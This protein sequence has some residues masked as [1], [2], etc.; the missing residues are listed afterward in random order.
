MACRHFFKVVLEDTIRSGKLEIPRKFARDYGN[1]LSNPVFIKVPNGEI[2]ELEF[3]KSGGKMWLQDGWQNFAEHYSVEPGHFL[4]FKYEG[5]GYFHVIIFDR[6]ATEIEYPDI[7][8]NEGTQKQEVKIKQ[9]SEDDEPVSI[10]N[11]ISHGLR[12]KPGLQCPRPL[13]TMKSEP[14]LSGFSAGT[15][16]GEM[17]ST[18]ASKVKSDEKCMVLQRVASAFQSTNPFFLVLMQPTYVSHNP[19]HSCILGIPREFSRLFLKQNGNVVLCDSNGKSWAA[20]YATSLGS[21]QRSYV[22]LC[23]GWGAFVRDKNLQ[24]GDV[25]AFELINCK[26]IS[27][28]V[29]IFEGKKSGFHGSPPS[30]D[31]YFSAKRESG[32]SFT[33][34]LKA[35]ETALEKALAFT[36]EN[37]FL[38]VVLR[39]SYIRRHALCISNHF[40][41]KHFESALTSVDVN[42]CLSN[43]KSWPAKY[44]QRSIGNP[45]GKI[46]HGWKA[47]VND[48]NL[49]PGDVCVLEMT[50]HDTKI[51]FKVIIF[52]A[53]EHANSHP[54]EGVSQKPLGLTSQSLKAATEMTSTPPFFRSVVLPLHLKEKRAGI[55]FGFVEQ[56]LKPNMETVILK[57]ED[58]SW[59]VKIASNPQNQQ[60]RFTNGWIEFARENFLREGDICVYELDAVN[61]GLLNVCISKSDD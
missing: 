7:N 47:F 46:C 60:A 10:M 14:M 39:P 43:G 35:R 11:E 27:F 33:Q 29:S 17:E 34:P 32:T 42:L 51:S 53:I 58:R 36:S 15:G 61:H 40:A 54:L 49:Q 31:G 5:H 16:R 26:Q 6:T 48:N 13:K 19:K 18:T 44:H 22:R 23:N 55:P 30:T 9:E 1:H 38:V 3:T 25:C 57:V 56:Y 24:V 37:P 50:N 45:N 2:W 28:K 52:K 12:E 4:V 8:D 20:K 59:P 21:N 41:R